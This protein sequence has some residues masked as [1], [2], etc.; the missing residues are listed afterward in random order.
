MAAKTIG[1]W[2]YDPEALLRCETCGWRGPG[3]A[4]QEP[5]D[6][7]LD[8]H[9][10]ECDR[11]LLIVPYPTTKQTRAAAAAG[12]ERAIA[13]LP[14]YERMEARAERAKGTHLTA[15]EQLPELAGEELVI[16][17]DLEEAD[18]ERWTVLRHDGA[19]LWRELAYWEGYERFAEVFTIG[20]ARY[21]ERLA[22]LRPTEASEMYLYG[23]KLSAPDTVAALNAGLK[24]RGSKRA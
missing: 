4:N 7:L 6:T 20:A 2:D 17:W 10:P 13:E 15:P 3:S 11:M 24:E 5:Y 18:D 21:G 9:C 16:E 19:E 12:N 1:Y 23:D 14:S 8:V 22:E